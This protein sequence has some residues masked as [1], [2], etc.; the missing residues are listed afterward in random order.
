MSESQVEITDQAVRSAMNVLLPIVAPT[1]K[2][3]RQAIEAALF[4]LRVVPRERLRE[5]EAS[6]RAYQQ[7]IRQVERERDAARR[8]LEM[9]ATA[10]AEQAIYATAAREQRDAAV[11]HAEAADWL[12]TCLDDV[13]AGKP[14]RGMDEAREGYRHARRTPGAQAPLSPNVCPDCDGTGKAKSSVSSGE[15]TEARESRAIVGA[16]LA[17]AGIPASALPV[18]DDVP[19]GHDAAEAWRLLRPLIEAYVS[20]P[21]LDRQVA[22]TSAAV[23]RWESMLPDGVVPCVEAARRVAGE[24]ESPSGAGVRGMTAPYDDSKEGRDAR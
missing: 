3:L 16:A 7:T 17:E 4:E 23:G 21:T 22:L 12:I 10:R 5:V 1:K 6:A 18:G 2:A 19:S 14:V 9:E 13:S 24:G 11:C 15:G 20:D 8:A